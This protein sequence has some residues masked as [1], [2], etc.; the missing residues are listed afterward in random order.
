MDLV[1]VAF[2]ELVVAALPADKVPEDNEA[3]CT[4]GGEGGP[5]YYWI[6]EE[7]EFD[8]CD[9]GILALK[10]LIIKSIKR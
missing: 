9:M 8:G 7:E 4:E 6:T 10:D 5:V 1:D 2:L 3:E